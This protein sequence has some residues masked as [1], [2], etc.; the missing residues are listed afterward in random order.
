IA[1][2][3]PTFDGHDYVAEA[4]KN[5]AASALVHRAPKDSDDYHDRLVMVKDTFAALQDLGRAARARTRARIVGVT[6]SVGKTGTKEALKRSLGVQGKTHASEGNL[7]NH[8]GVPLSL[9]RMPAESDFGV[10]E[11]GMNHAGEIAPLSKLVRPHVAVITAVEA[12]HLEFFNSVADIADE[13]ASI[14][15]G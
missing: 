8:W 11:L 7:N 2:E 12:V 13:K 14:M 4:F 10:F 15:A 3:G 9:A 1:L 5:G 6:G